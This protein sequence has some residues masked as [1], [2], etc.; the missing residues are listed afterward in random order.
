VMRN[1]FAFSAGV[2]KTLYWQFL[3]NRANPEQLMTLMYGKIG[4]FG[5]ENG[6]LKKHYPVADAYKRMAEKLAGVRAVRRIN[7]PARPTIFLFE[8]DRGQRGPLFVLWERRDEF[9]GE[10]SPAV[11]FDWKWMTP[12]VSAMDA[13][14]STIPAQVAE[15]KLHLRVSLTPIFVEPIQ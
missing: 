6:V 4:M 8:V 10:N 14:G 7:V 1:L 3:D 11:A 5:Y 12:N 13:L 15:G 2:Q 9:T